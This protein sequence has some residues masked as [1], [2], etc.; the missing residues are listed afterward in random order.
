ML[1]AGSSF[2]QT[3]YAKYLSGAGFRPRCPPF[4]RTLRR[5]A[6]RLAGNA[7]RYYF[8]VNTR[9]VRSKLQLLLCP[10]TVRGHWNRMLEQA[11]QRAGVRWSSHAQ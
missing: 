6:R 10:F 11:R 9:Y 5:T 3:N 1:G 4:P 7:L 2:G 8:T